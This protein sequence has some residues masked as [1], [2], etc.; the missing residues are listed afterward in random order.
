[1]KNQAMYDGLLERRSIRSFKPEQ[2]SDED[3]NAV[4]TAGTYAPTAMGA[5]APII[6]AV[7]NPDDVKA[8]NALNA[9]FGAGSTPYYG[10]PTI[11]LVLAPQGNTCA[12]LDGAAVMTTLLNA[13]H[14]VGLGACWVNRPQ[15]M[16]QTNEGRAMLK[17]WGVEGSWVGVG[18]IALGYPAGDAPKAK[19][20]KENYFRIIK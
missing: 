3:L 19:P 20:R 1:M 16:F 14:A 2:V 17:R 12:D 9:V 18:S 4:L 5:Q 6:I 13:A 11:L 15:L 7:Q 8:L 10:A